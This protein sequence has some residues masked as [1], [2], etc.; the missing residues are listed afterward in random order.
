MIAKSLST[1]FEK[2]DRIEKNNIA[3][4]F[5]LDAYVLVAGGFQSGTG[6]S[7]KVELLD[8]YGNIKTLP[9]LPSK[10]NYATGGLLFGTPVICGCYADNSCYMLSNDG[11]SWRFLASMSEAKGFAA[12]VVL[13]GKLWV[14]GG[15]NGNRLQ[16]SEFITID[17]KVTQGP[18][19]PEKL[20]QHASIKIEDLIFVTGGYNGNEVTSTTRIYS[21]TGPSFLKEGPRMNK[22]RASHGITSFRSN[23][24]DGRSVIM[25]AGGH[26]GPRSV[27]I[28]DH[29]QPGSTWTE[30]KFVFKDI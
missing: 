26:G 16:S 19:L 18:N 6:R 2:N 13:P 27:E 10:M 9:D 1:F 21:V 29:S 17:G 5:C 14:S 12:A 15:W 22:I 7:E 3:L 28:W 25:V 23:N 8:K 30:S 24:H 4:C 11:S 20:S